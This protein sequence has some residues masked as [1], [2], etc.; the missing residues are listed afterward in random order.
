MSREFAAAPPA[1]ISKAR[2]PSSSAPFFRIAPTWPGPSNMSPCQEPS[3]LRRMTL[4][5]PSTCVVF[6]IVRQC[7]TT[8][9]LCG[10]VMQMP[11]QLG[12][13]R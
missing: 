5:E 9:N 4:A 13:L 12:R 2:L 1:P 8:A 6:D 3:G 10:T 7:G 11:S